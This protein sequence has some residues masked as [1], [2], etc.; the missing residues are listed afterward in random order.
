MGDGKFRTLNLMGKTID[1]CE[2]MASSSSA[3]SCGTR[4][5]RCERTSEPTPI[6]G[7]F[8]STICNEFI[9]EFEKPEP[10]GYKKY[11]HLTDAQREE[12]KLDKAFWISLKKSDVWVMK[13]KERG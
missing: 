12:S 1:L 11:A 9:L 8:S 13:P 5:T 10:K 6:L 3:T 7:A 4:P 2:Q